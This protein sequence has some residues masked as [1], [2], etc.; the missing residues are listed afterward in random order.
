MVY[1][2]F[3]T[4]LFIGKARYIRTALLL[5][6][7]EHGIKTYAMPSS[8]QYYRSNGT[9]SWESAPYGKNGTAE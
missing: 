9:A 2:S 1:S 7:V 6:R 3:G 4:N 8:F 5:I